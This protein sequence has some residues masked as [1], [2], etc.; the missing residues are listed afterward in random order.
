MAY[1]PPSRVRMGEIY[2]QLGDTAGAVEQYARVVRLWS[3]CEPE[4]RPWLNEIQRKL[5]RL[6]SS[7]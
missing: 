2:Q 3:N 4:L 6:R 1:L 7:N 5:A